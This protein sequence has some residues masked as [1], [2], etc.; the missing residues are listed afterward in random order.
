MDAVVF[1]SVRVLTTLTVTELY[2]GGGMV[3]WTSSI[4]A[5]LCRKLDCDYWLPRHLLYL[6]ELM[7]DIGP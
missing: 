2:R 3:M 7:Y 5:S 4:A 6:H 1:T